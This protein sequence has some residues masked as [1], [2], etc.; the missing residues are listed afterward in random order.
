MKTAL[1]NKKG[2]GSI[3]TGVKIIIAIVIGLLILGVLYALF[4]GENGIFE[5]LDTEVNDMMDYEQ[6]LRYERYYDEE[7]GVY[8]LR[9]SYDGKTW[10][11]PAMPAYSETATVYK[12]ITN[13]SDD[14]P[15]E[16]A[17]IKDGD[18]HY[19]L[20]SRDGGV[21]WTEQLSFKAGSDGITH[22]YY[23]TSSKLPKGAPSFTGEKF[24]VRFHGGYQN[25][26]T[27]SSDGL[28]WKMPSWSDII[29]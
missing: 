15:I 10:K 5:R 19:I 12:T 6:S 20:N 4:S 16:V 21:T 23:G 2:E 27:I 25:Y 24:V 13:K 11:T 28:T 14:N 7:S 29:T 8:A 9:Y 17:V 3:D 1:L 18:Q 22:C 26:Y